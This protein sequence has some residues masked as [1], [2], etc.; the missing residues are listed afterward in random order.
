M[1]GFEDLGL[2]A[3][4]LRAIQD[5]GWTEPTPV[6]KEAIPVGLEGRDI[7][8]Q[9]QTGTGKTAT[10]GTIVMGRIPSGMKKPSAIVLCPTRELA[11]QVEQEL[12]R[13]SKYTKHRSVAIYGGSSY[14]MQFSKLKRGA[15]IIVG[16]PGRVKDLIEQGALDMS[17]IKEA[18]LDEADRMLDMGFEEEVNFIMGALPEE[19]QTMLFSATMAHEI[20]RLGGRFMVDPLELLVS[21]DEPCSD[22]VK[23]YYIPV[24]RGG[25]HERLEMIVGCNFPKTIVFCQTKKMVDDLFTEMGEKYKVGS[26]HGDM[27]QARRE[28]VVRNF[29]NDRFQILIATDVAARGLDINDVDVVVNYDVPPD[30]ETYLHR[31]GRTGRAGKEGIAISFVTKVEDRRVRMYEQETGKKISKIRIEDAMSILSG[32]TMHK[33]EPVRKTV[34]VIPSKTPAQRSTMVAMQINLGKEDACGRVQIT[35][36]VKSRAK[37][38][39]DLVGRVGLGNMTSFIEV[40][41]KYADMAAKA[42]SNSTYNGKKLFLQLAPKKVPYSQKECAR[43]VRQS[44]SFNKKDA[45]QG[46]Q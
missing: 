15:D 43:V 1:T 34:R 8:A 5:M 32:S 37:L 38:S 3:K 27:P 12:F 20:M 28:K 13:L 19:R 18:V 7:L 16:T 46:T 29:R 39:D 42:V 24:S 21:K 44:G 30:A 10:Y 2:D 25:K 4:I 22:L 9:A 40:N 23:Q 36:I 45:G 6:Q 33:P 14:N 41:E 11:G 26:L 17:C 35:E 31:I